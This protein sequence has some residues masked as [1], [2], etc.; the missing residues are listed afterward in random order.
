MDMT[1][2]TQEALDW[3]RLHTIQLLVT[4]FVIVLYI[5]LDRLGGPFLRKSADQ[6]DYAKS[7]ALKAIKVARLFT[8]L[9]GG[10]LLVVVWGIDLSPILIVSTT[11]ITLLGVA[12]FASWSLLSNITAYFVLL[13]HPGFARG[14]FIRVI[15]ADN[16]VEGSISNLFFFNVELLTQD[17]EI[18]LYPNN[19]M[20]S[21]VVVIDAKPRSASIGK[22]TA[23]K[24]LE[25]SNDQLP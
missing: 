10:F 4:L 7:A 11:V 2:F 5:V 23:E 24:P 8:A 25:S 12:L 15:E 1:S 21:R 9:L 19:L 16:Y 3:V 13:I 17:Q 22:I 14:S 6:G 18:V 20:M